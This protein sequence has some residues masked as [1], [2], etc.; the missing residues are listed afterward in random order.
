MKLQKYRDHEMKYYILKDKHVVEAKNLLEWCSWFEHSGERILR[1]SKF[2]DIVVS[3]VFLGIDHNF[4]GKGPPVV[5]ES[6]VF[7]GQHDQ[8]CRRCCTYPEALQQHNE[9]VQLVGVH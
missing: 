2:S 4:T 8:L 1:K 6:M 7:G 9:L 5:F 3:T